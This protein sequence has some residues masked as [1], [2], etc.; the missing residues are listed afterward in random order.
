MVRRVKVEAGGA[1]STHDI[2]AFFGRLKNILRFP[3]PSNTAMLTT[4]RRIHTSLLALL[5]L[6]VFD[7]L[8]LT[9]STQAQA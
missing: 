8:F 5:Y 3:R 2:R 4:P 9:P 6:M 1:R 7:S